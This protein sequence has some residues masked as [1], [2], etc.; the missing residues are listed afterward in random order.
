[1]DDLDEIGI[2]E[3][4]SDRRWQE[5]DRLFRCE[6]CHELIQT[7]K[8][9]PCQHSFCALCVESAL[10]AQKPTT[11]ECPTCRNPFQ[12]S[13]MVGNR[14]LDRILRV[15]VDVRADTVKAFEPPS[16]KPDP[17]LLSSKSAMAELSTPDP[18]Q[19]PVRN[20]V[21]CPVCGMVMPTEA[22][23]GAH[24]DEGCGK[25]R[26]RG[27]VM[28]DF[29]QRK[30][31]QP[32]SKKLDPEK[33]TINKKPKGYYNVPLKQLKG[34]CTAAGLPCDRPQDQLKELHRQ[35]VLRWNVACDSVE[36]KS[37]KQIVKEVL[38]WE[39]AKENDKRAQPIKDLSTHVRQNQDEFAKLM[40]QARPR[41]S[42]ST[43]S[44]ADT[45]AT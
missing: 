6:I 7:V 18:V 45:K 43:N 2:P 41:P 10:N 23:V 33:Y 16:E 24:L 17:Q 38:L 32:Q 8:T 29:I 21:A 9:T 31:A 11:K 27:R 12:A 22:E 15:Y 19:A 14:L 34:M 30:S 3:D 44:A 13:D 28:N 20:G 35:F 36:P 40:A 5:I 42:P 26:K 4:F 37:K 39:L 1:M 25:S